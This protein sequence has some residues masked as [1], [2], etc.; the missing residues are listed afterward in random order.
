M[1]NLDLFA[2]ALNAGTFHLIITL[3][4]KTEK[5]GFKLLDISFLRLPLVLSFGT[6]AKFSM[7]ST[8]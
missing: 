1:M 2:F 4:D 5:K 3:P 7:I 8:A 6:E